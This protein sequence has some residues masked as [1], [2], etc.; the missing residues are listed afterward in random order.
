MGSKYSK[1]FCKLRITNLNSAV[2]TTRHE[3]STPQRVGQTN[4]KLTEEC[5]GI[6]GTANARKSYLKRPKY[7]PNQLYLEVGR[8]K[9]YGIY[10]HGKRH[11][12]NVFLR[13]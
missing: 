8:L 10:S 2:R 4:F 12:E 1:V 5:I 9:A 13:E 11:K 3:K 7:P 6:S